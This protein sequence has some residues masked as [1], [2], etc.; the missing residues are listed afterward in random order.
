M[1]EVANENVKLAAMMFIGAVASIL[2]LS[3]LAIHWFAGRP[4]IRFRERN[5]IPWGAVAS[6]PAIF[7]ASMALIPAIAAIDAEPVRVPAVSE[8]TRQVA[9]SSLT[10]LTLIGAISVAIALASGATDRDLGMPASGR[11]LMADIYVG[12]VTWLALLAPVYGLQALVVTLAGETSQHPLIQML[13]EESDPLLLITACVAAVIA[14]P[15]SEEIAFRLLFQGWLE[16]RGTTWL[17]ILVSSFLF[18]VAHATSGPDPVALFVLAI[19]LGY[20]Y[21]RTHHIVPC[22]VAHALFNATSMI[23]L[24]LNQ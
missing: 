5:P 9:A 12:C 7:M 10:M 3:L 2:T 24:A 23:A 1:D 11:E 16:Q 13:V 4:L 14:A 17:P 20:V 19:V 22:I 8:F 18:S 15:L 6:L 21:Q